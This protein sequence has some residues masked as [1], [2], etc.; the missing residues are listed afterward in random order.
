MAMNY[1]ARSILRIYRM[2]E[3]KS[4]HVV[5]KDITVQILC[6]FPVTAE[7]AEC[8]PDGEPQPRLS[9]TTLPKTHR[10]NE[11]VQIICHDITY[12]D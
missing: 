5:I 7:Y 11:Y 8:D 4:L 12:R 9:A 6:A 2:C 3:G 10:T 1:S